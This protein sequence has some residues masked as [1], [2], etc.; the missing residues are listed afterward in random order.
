MSHT[1]NGSK[2]WLELLGMLQDRGTDK[3]VIG[4]AGDV[5]G[6]ISSQPGDRAKRRQVSEDDVRRV[7]GLATVLHIARSALIVQGDVGLHRGKEIGAIV[8]RI[9]PQRVVQRVLGGGH[10]DTQRTSYTL[11]RRHSLELRV[12]GPGGA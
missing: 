10:N 8:I 5:A 9:P 11:A 1:S 7:V 4:E 6:D 2:R 12:T 3:P